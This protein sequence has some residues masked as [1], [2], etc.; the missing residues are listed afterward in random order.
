M[1]NRLRRLIGPVLLVLAMH[2]FVLSA[3]G[4]HP[5]RVKI[6]G[7]IELP[8]EVLGVELPEGEIVP[9]AS[10]RVATTDEAGRGCVARVHVKVGDNFIVMLPD[11]Q[12]VGRLANEVDPTERPFEPMNHA[13]MAKELLDDPRLRGFQTHQT[14]HFVFVYNASPEFAKV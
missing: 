10:D 12:L 1:Q 5:E 6:Y 9:Y 4:Q 2:C 14:D 8:P 13:A 3:S 11:G 7:S